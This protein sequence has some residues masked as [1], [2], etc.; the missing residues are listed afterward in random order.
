M[1]TWT[2]LLASRSSRVPSLEFSCSLFTLM[3]K[4]KT[5]HSSLS[6]PYL[7][8]SLSLSSLSSSSFLLT[9]SVGSHHGYQNCDPDPTILNC[10]N[11][12]NHCRIN[13]IVGSQ[14]A[15]Y[16]I[17]VRIISRITGFMIFYFILICIILICIFTLF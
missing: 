7:H 11:D 8:R 1:F 13:I 5:K 14:I 4:N 12:P 17:G 6:L 2:L 16:R 3:Q 15:S 9:L 10:Q